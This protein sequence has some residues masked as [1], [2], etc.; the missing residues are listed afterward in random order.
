[1]ISERKQ[2][3]ESIQYEIELFD[4]S[5]ERDIVIGQELVYNGHASGNKS[6]LEVS[7]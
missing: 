5:S 7:V 3:A 4:T 6:F 2:D 1:M